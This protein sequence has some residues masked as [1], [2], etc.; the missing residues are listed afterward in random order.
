MDPSLPWNRNDTKLWTEL[1]TQVR[2][3]GGSHSDSWHILI[4]E[5]R[6]M[7]SAQKPTGKETRS[8]SARNTTHQ[9]T[10][11]GPFA[12][13]GMNAWPL[14]EARAAHLAPEVEHLRRIGHRGLREWGEVQPSLELR[15]PMPVSLGPLLTCLAVNPKTSFC[16][17][18]KD[19]AW[20]SNFWIPLESQRKH[21]SARN[22]HQLLDWKQLSD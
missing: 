9:V 21:T 11:F 7:P 2:P 8:K 18:R 19:Y 16:I 15:V 13:S 1:I 6:Q 17:Q 10:I 5:Q 4:V 14:Q 20:G 12:D 3:A 22:F